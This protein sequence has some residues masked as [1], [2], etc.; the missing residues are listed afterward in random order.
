MSQLRRAE[1]YKGIE[2]P[3]GEL[4]HEAAHL[5]AVSRVVARRFTR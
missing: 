1:S 5:A 4:W 2:Q 3:L